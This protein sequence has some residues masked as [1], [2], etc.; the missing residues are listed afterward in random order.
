MV[1]R[2]D[3][4]PYENREHAAAKHQLLK[5][6]IQRYTMILGVSEARSLAFVD[7]FAGPW[8]SG[9]DDCTDTSFGVSVHTLRQCAETLRARLGRQPEI[10]ALWIEADDSAFAQL[11]SKASELSNSRVNI[12]AEHGRFQD[13][14]Q[15][16]VEFL[17]PANHAF[18][19][20]DPKGYAGQID[21][22]VLA[23]LLRRPRTELLINYMWDHIRYLF[24][25]MEN[26]KHAAN[27]RRLCGDHVDELLKLTDPRER[28][29]QSAA[30]Y[31]SELRATDTSIGKNR[32]RVMSYPIL[33]TRGERHTK[34]YLFHATHS[35]KG[36]VTFAEECDKNQPIQDLI[37]QFTQQ[38]RREKR[39]GMTDM[40]PS[41]VKA[42]KPVVPPAT[43]PWLNALPEL[44]DEMV[45][46]TEV[47][48]RLL[49][50][51][52]CLPSALLEGAKEL[53]AEGTLVN[54]SAKRPRRTRHVNYEKSERV[55]RLR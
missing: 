47:W 30:A 38:S 24:G 9:R 42:P 2:D 55:R 4:V 51:G 3:L 1:N 25:H 53:I 26:E 48:A 14:I 22:A 46:D 11:S 29:I 8:Q 17:G 40:F 39:S 27:L 49:E 54:L 36:L 7:G 50:E 12:V 23:P 21:P 52:P 32:L 37:F 31:A 33:D 41:L 6:Y 43:E 13:K 15:R 28:E 45:V 18:I 5:N 34:Y 16:I 19:F 20:I 35:S 44:G 10:R